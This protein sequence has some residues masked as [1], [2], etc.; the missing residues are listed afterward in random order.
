MHLAE[1]KRYE[2]GYRAATLRNS[3]DGDGFSALFCLN[4]SK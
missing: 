1:A 4:G 2:M 3:K